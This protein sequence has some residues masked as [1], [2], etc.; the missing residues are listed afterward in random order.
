MTQT[1][2]GVSTEDVD[3][4][5]SSDSQLMSNEDLADIQEE[6]KTPPTTAKDDDCQKSSN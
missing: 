4:L 5:S 2:L 1:N 3:E 6:N